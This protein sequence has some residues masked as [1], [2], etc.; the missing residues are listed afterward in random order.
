M[1]QEAYVS[2]EI[3]KLLKEKR[4]NE[5][6]SSTYDIAV[7]GGKPIFYKY[8]V[9]QFFPNGMKNSDDKYGMVISAPTHQMVLAWLRNEYNI[10]IEVHYNRYCETYTYKIIYSPVELEDKSIGCFDTYEEA[11]EDALMQVLTHKYYKDKNANYD[12]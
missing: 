11:I 12:K 1:I 5:Q 2:F 9:L 4:F 10:H 8:D 6:C 3:A 7:E